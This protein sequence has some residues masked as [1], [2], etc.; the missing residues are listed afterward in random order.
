MMFEI[1]DSCKHAQ[2]NYTY[3]QCVLFIQ[4]FHTRLIFIFASYN[5][6]KYLCDFIHVIIFVT[7]SK[8]RKNPKLTNIVI[9]V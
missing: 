2:I 6:L 1:E 5:I 4:S 8:C 7:V 3:G 9:H